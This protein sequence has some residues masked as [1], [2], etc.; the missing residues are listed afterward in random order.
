MGLTRPWQHISRDMMSR[1]YIDR[2]LFKWSFVVKST[3]ALYDDYV[4][5]RYELRRRAERQQTTRRRIVEAAVA[6]HGSVGLTRTTITQIADL[7]GVGRQTVY[8][9]FPDEPTLVEACSGLYWE[10]NPFPD[11]ERWRTVGDPGER[12]QL[13]LRESYAY[14]RRT[15]AM[16]GPV[17]AEAPD[18]PVTQRYHEFWR[19]AADVVASAWEV[20]GRRRT[21]LRAAIRHAIGFSTWHSLVRQHGLTDRQ[22]IDLMRRLTCE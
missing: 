5:R 19:R 6:L 3:N 1:N 22:A 11:P 16:I 21:L 15:E 18:Q 8:R 12:L 2:L 17:L 9:H 10:R 14:H 13:A 7:A 4:P 20:R